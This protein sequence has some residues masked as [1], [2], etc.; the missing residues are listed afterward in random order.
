[1]NLTEYLLFH[2]HVYIYIGMVKSSS[3][4]N[5]SGNDINRMSKSIKEEMTTLKQDIDILSQKL[6][7]GAGGKGKPN[8]VHVIPVP[9][10]FR[11]EHKEKGKSIEQYYIQLLKNTIKKTNQCFL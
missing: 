2:S 11:G 9:D 1:M 10:K 8:F 3:M 4:F 5:D 7:L 6:G